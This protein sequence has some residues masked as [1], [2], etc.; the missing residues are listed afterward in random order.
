[1]DIFNEELKKHKTKNNEKAMPT[2]TLGDTSGS[3]GGSGHGNRPGWWWLRGEALG[4]GLHQVRVTQ[5]WGDGSLHLGQVQVRPPLEAL[6]QPDNLLNVLRLLAKLKLKT[7]GKVC[8]FG[9]S[10]QQAVS[11]V[12]RHSSI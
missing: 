10:R 3:S 4:E 1:M 11:T 9:E 6:Q 12:S 2:R 8:L 5:Q 7:Q